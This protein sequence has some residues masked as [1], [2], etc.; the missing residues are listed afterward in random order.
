MAHLG[1]YSYFLPLGSPHPMANGYKTP[2][3]LPELGSVLQSAYCSS[4]IMDQEKVRLSCD[5]S[6]LGALSLSCIPHSVSNIF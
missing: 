1:S 5:L 4:T 3:A 2:A 6:L